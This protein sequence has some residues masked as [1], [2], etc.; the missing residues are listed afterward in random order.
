MS[1]TLSALWTW[2][3]C[4]RAHQS[5]V[6]PCIPDEVWINELWTSNSRTVPPYAHT[7]IH[8]HKSS[9]PAWWNL[10]RTKMPAKLTSAMVRI[11]QLEHRDQDEEQQQQQRR[12]F[13][14]LQLCDV[15]ESAVNRAERQTASFTKQIKPLTGR[16]CPQHTGFSYSLHADLCRFVSQVTFIFSKG[17]KT[18]D[19]SSL[20]EIIFAIIDV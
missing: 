5:K 7:H 4:P 6:W 14:G 15:W 1:G 12:D 17:S 10:Q 2:Q 18:W 13:K 16:V 11:S 9:N 8:T 19:K 20:V 3:N